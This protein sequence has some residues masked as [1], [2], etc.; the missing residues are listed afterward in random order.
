MKT[1]NLLTILLIVILFS[2]SSQVKTNGENLNFGIFEMIKIKDIPVHVI[3]SIEAKNVRLGKDKESAVIGYISESD[4]SVLQVDFS[5][6]KIKLVK[7]IHT[8]DTD[9]GYYVIAAIK[10]NAVINISDIKK[11]KAT[12]NNVKIIFNANGVGKWAKI[13]KKNV[14]NT[15]AIVID[16]Q[17]LSMPGIFSEIKEGMAYISGLENKSIAKEISKSLNASVAEQISVN[18]SK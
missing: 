9:S 1:F 2:C 12:G 10:L 6:E 4:T 11:T 3:D 14:G 13:T 17:I 18:N 7:M 16:N 8:T 15:I 5:K